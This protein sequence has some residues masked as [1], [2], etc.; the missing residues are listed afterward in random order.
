[1]SQVG[2]SLKTI[3]ASGN[4]LWDLRDKRNSIDEQI[5]S[6]QKIA[7]KLT[8]LANKEGSKRIGLLINRHSVLMHEINRLMD[9]RVDIVQRIASSSSN[10]TGMVNATTNRLITAIS[11]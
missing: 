6:K 4:Y 8:E 7:N 11:N 1:M 9:E 2:G 3:A 10:F 5:E